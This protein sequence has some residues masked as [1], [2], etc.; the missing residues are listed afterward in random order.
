MK[1][2]YKKMRIGELA[3]FLCVDRNDILLWEKEFSIKITPT[4]NGQKFYSSKDIQKLSTIKKMLKEDSFSLE[5]A[6]EKILRRPTGKAS[7][8]TTAFETFSTTDQSI[9]TSYSETAVSLIPEADVPTLCE[10]LC[11]EMQVVPTQP[12]LMREEIKEQTSVAPSPDE[13]QS[14]ERY[15]GSVELYPTESAALQASVQEQLLSLRE[16]LVKLRE[17]L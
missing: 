3:N 6:K 2:T 1:M 7:S 12:E 14:S 8:E 13:S 11:E 10:I 9:E 16:R 4:L 17:L 5:Q 15:S